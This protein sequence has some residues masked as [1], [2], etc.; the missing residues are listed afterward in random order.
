MRDQAMSLRIMTNKARSNQPEVSSSSA[1]QNHRKASGPR[2]IA[3]T[4]GKGG[5]G[6]TNVV[7]NL[8]I[9]LSTHGK[10]IMVLDADLGLANLDVLLGLIPKF[11][12]G[13]LINGTKELSDIV[14]EGPGGVRIIPAGSGIQQLTELR[15]DQRERLMQKLLSLDAG[16]DFLFIDTAAGISDNVMHFLSMAGEVIVVCAPEPTA[17]V[18]AYAVIK[19]IIASDR[20]KPIK[21]LVNSVENSQEAEQVFSQVNRVVWRFL[22]REVQLFGY[23][24][25]D[26]SVHLAVKGQTSVVESFPNSRASLC[27][28]NLA[29]QLANDGPQIYF[30][31]NSV[32]TS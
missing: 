32:S 7:A 31:G 3:I 18:D 14:L 21:L 24:Y 25:A 19:S 12:L 2:I 11:H 1:I 29:R 17:I 20:E 28:K 22:N 26:N 6:K 4:S 30:L 13:H 15:E 10:H 27:F 16:T 9:A 8:A 5:V 23:V